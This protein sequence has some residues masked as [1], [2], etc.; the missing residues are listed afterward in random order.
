MSASIR[1]GT[2]G[3]SYKEWL[4]GFYPEKLPGPKMLAHY[5]QRLPAVEINYTFR[6]MPRREMLEKWAVQTPQPFRFALKAPQRITHQKRLKDVSDV[7]LAFVRI[8]A[9]LGDKMGPL[10]FQLPPFMKKDVPRVEDFLAMLP[11]GLRVA[12][13]FRHASWFDDE[14]YETLRTHR[15][16]LCTAEGEGLA[17]PLVATTDWGYLRL[18]LGVYTDEA[19]AAW[20]EKLCALSWK[21][22]FVYFKHDEGGAPGFAAK[23][24]AQLPRVPSPKEPQP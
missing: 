22:A 9:G 16:V 10:L 15:A 2:S 3:F 11:S 5:A 20:A 13:E 12:L 18:R 8:A 1:I 17:S 6:A 21:E 7:V 19:I 14:V 23:L 24:V 4:G